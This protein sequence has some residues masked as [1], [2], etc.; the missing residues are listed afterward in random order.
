MSVCKTNLKSN[1]FSKN[2]N[3]NY[4]DTILNKSE[5][6]LKQVLNK[7]EYKEFLNRVNFIYKFK[8]KKEIIKAFNKTYYDF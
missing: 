5:K 4:L 1:L 8:S 6:Y 3:N 2:L 7:K